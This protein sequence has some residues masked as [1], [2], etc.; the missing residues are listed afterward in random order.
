MDV[1]CAESSFGVDYQKDQTGVQQT[2]LEDL[3]LEA[4]FEGFET[5]TG[6]TCFFLG[7][8]ANIGGVFQCAASTYYLFIEQMVAIINFCSLWR[9]RCETPFCRK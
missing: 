2:L 7:G 8:M 1:D 6:P 5:S 4:D 3:T 9:V